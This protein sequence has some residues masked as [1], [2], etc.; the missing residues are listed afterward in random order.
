MDI[1][2]QSFYQLIKEDIPLQIFFVICVL[3]CILSIK[4]IIIFSLLLFV[5]YKQISYK[6]MWI[7][8]TGIKLLTIIEYYKIWTK[9]I[10]TECIIES[11]IYGAILLRIGKRFNCIKLDIVIAT[12]G[13]I[14]LF[15]VTNKLSLF[16]IIISKL[17]TI[18]FVIIREIDYKQKFFNKVHIQLVANIYLRTPEL[19]SGALN[20]LMSGTMYKDIYNYLSTQSDISQYADELDKIKNI[21][22]YIQDIF[23]SLTPPLFIQYILAF[24]TQLPITSLLLLTGYTYNIII[25]LCII[26]LI[27]TVLTTEP[28]VEKILFGQYFTEQR[29]LLEK[30]LRYTIDSISIAQNGLHVII[31]AKNSKNILVETTVKIT[32]KVVD[33]IKYSSSIIKNKTIN[34]VQNHPYITL[35]STIGITSGVAGLFLW[36]RRK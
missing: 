10:V 9:L 7:V 26:E 29:E 20:G 31:I 15:T 22:K 27:L 16:E 19:L 28:N 11:L 4:I 18:L 32:T 21:L 33:S 30:G 35:A 12:L 13:F 25:L 6:M 8:F 5:L 2:T 14:E 34:F 3:K 24:I 23:T 17:F 36:K 1:F